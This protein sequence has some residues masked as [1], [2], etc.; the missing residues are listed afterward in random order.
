M[1]RELRHTRAAEEKLCFGE[2]GELKGRV[3]RSAR[4]AHSRPWLK[5]DVGGWKGCQRHD[6]TWPAWDWGPSGVVGAPTYGT[7][8]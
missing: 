3:R 7:S 6:T 5:H 4:P 8:I 2:K 1:Q